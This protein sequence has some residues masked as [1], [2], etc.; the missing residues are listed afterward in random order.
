MSDYNRFDDAFRPSDA[1]MN[2]WNISKTHDPRTPPRASPHIS[3][4][5]QFRP[6]SG[7][8]TT[9][10]ETLSPGTPLYH[11]D[12][13]LTPMR[14]G[15]GEPSG[16]G[17]PVR[18]QRPERGTVDPHLGPAPPDFLGGSMP[19]QTLSFGSTIHS[20]PPP[21]RAPLV[22]EELRQDPAGKLSPGVLVANV[23]DK[24]V[25][26]E[27]ELGIPPGFNGS[28]RQA[29]VGYQG[30]GGMA[31]GS[32]SSSHFEP[33]SAGAP[34]RTWE[35]GYARTSPMVSPMKSA[36]SERDRLEAAAAYYHS[37][38]QHV[39][40]V[41]T[42]AP[43]SSSYYGAAGQPSSS[44]SA[45]STPRRGYEG[46]DLRQ[47]GFAP[48]FVPSPVSRTG[49]GPRSPSP[50]T[51]MIE[52]QPITHQ[53]LVELRQ[54][55]QR[56]MPFS[57]SA[58]SQQIPQHLPH[59]RDSSGMDP[60]YTSASH[61]RQHQT[62]VSLGMH[63]HPPLR[64]PHSLHSLHSPRILLAVNRAT[65]LPSAA[66]RSRM[67]RSQGTLSPW[68]ARILIIP[69]LRRLRISGSYLPRTPP[70]PITNICPS[71][72]LTPLGTCLWKSIT[73]ISLHC[74]VQ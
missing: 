23:V 19:Q 16:F 3:S 30:D 42:G 65:A 50:V 12:S 31:W 35:M 64:S 70:L 41:S 58:A 26:D 37:Q 68:Q 45:P 56:G 52:N 15:F 47:G 5:L 72:I 53:E 7:A 29:P 22:R 40:P 21:V 25:Q 67:D 46:Q 4:P 32:T 51:Y 14:L 24:V 69:H 10:K 59:H 54:Q 9:E 61:M 28:V 34:T 49:P 27:G 60:G 63:H 71:A 36:P 1:E 18:S 57:L 20:P 8:P 48:G 11:Y 2:D 6:P 43:Y 74:E 62:P 66:L 17:T 33:S 73:T 39:A 44:E 38:R 55:A 13:G